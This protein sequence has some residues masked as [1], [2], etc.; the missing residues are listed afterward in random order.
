[1]F[2]GLKSHHTRSW[3]YLQL[4]QIAS[5][6]LRAIFCIL[7]PRR[8][9]VYHEDQ[10]VEQELSVSLLGRFSFAWAGGLLKYV[11]KNKDLELHDIPKLAISQ[12][13]AF[14]RE[15]F[16]GAKKNRKLWVA[17]IFAHAG[18]LAIQMIFTMA[19][20]VLSF[21]PQV[22]LFQILKSLEL[23]GTPYWNL[24]ACYLWVLALGGSMVLSSSVEAWMY[25]IAI[26]RVAVPINTELSALV[27]AKAMRRKDVKHTT[28]DATDYSINGSASNEDKDDQKDDQKALKKGRQ[29]IVNHVAVDT[30]RILN[31]AASSYNI[32]QAIFKIIIGACFLVQ[33]LG[34]RS[35]FA[36]L[37]VAALVTPLNWYAAKKYSEF[38][39]LLMKERDKK[40]DIVTE[41]LEGIRQIKFSALEESWQK[42][43]QGVREDELK[44]LWACLLADIWLLA[45]WVLGPIGLSAVSLV[46]Y[47]SING[48]LTASVAFT[49]MVVFNTLEVSLAVVPE[50]V[51]MG[52]EAKNSAK[53]IDQFLATSD[54]TVNTVPAD[55][56]AFENAEVAW[57]A[58]DTTDSNNSE[59]RFIL[60]DV[61]LKFPPKSLSVISGRTGSG[62]SLLL[63]SILGEC[64]VLGGTLKV[65][66]PPSITERYDHLA[67]KENWIID[68]AIAYVAQIPWIENE[69][70]KKNILFGL[71]DDKE[72]YKKVISACALK[73]DFEMFDDGDLTDIGPKGINLSG[74]QRWRISLA[75]ALYSRAGILILDDIFSALDAHTGRH[76]FEH[77]LTGDLGKGRTRV[78]VTHHVALCL[79]RTDYSV[80]LE[81]G[82]IKYAGT[83]DD[84]KQSHHLED[85]LRE[86]QAEEDGFSVADGDAKAAES[87]PTK[88]FVE[89]EKRK[90]G[91]VELKVYKAYL[92]NGGSKPFWILIISVYLAYISLMI[93]RVSA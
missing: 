13:A 29:G 93:A 53:R 17:I 72:R 91:A 16:E 78:L 22:A 14:R 38:Q 88:Q 19:T 73:K 64:D 37:S 61:T 47:A 10:L 12:R 27:F 59:E 15:R 87:R 84:L 82:R 8:P 81:N 60:R 35:A 7:L 34:W 65:P 83:V 31:F 71:P 80:F 33:I 32:P 45:I 49:A 3:I 69:T 66:V 62:K 86:D 89:E 26:S 28:K 6:V 68:S 90:D 21:G 74:G 77:A 92:E 1:V 5:A 43:V 18:P 63:S 25:W 85:I 79:P 40:L 30:Q 24:E 56:I 50:V 52:I 4:A 48:G 46:T 20:C 39:D 23:R 36:G 76:V 75:R 2:S 54:R 44:A 11:V 51:S 57:P 67:T 42:R 55:Y 9:D 41:V 58:E 70:I